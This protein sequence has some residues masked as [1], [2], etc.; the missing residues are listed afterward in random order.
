M[1]DK[2][3]ILTLAS[4]SPRRK[5][6]IRKITDNFTVTEPVCEEIADGEPHFIAETNATRKGR[7]ADGDF[8]V[9]CDTVV[10]CDGVIYGKP[11]DEIR[12]VGMLKALNGRTHTVISGVYVRAEKEETVFCDES[13]VTFRTLTD[14][15]IVSY[16]K[17][18]R[19]LDK[20]GAYGLQDGVV[21][22]EFSGSYDNIVGLPTE[23]LREVL[24]KYVYVKE[25][26]DN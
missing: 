26:S 20:A 24:R 10:A 11:M 6:L 16:V 13:F 19:P 2:K 14:E 21:V 18:Y 12:A 4:S 22:S 1:L 5:E 9:A 15:E 23:K 17:K 8:V 3:Q 7:A 25:E